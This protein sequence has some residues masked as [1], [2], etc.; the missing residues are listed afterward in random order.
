MLF[1]EISPITYKISVAKCRFQRKV[2]DMLG[3]DKFAKTQ[4]KDIL[5]VSVYEHKS[6]IRRRLGNVDMQLQENKAVNLALAAPKVDGILIK[7][8]ETFSFWQ[9]VGQTSARKG[10]KEGLQISSGRTSAG[11]GGGMCQFTNLIHWMVLHSPLDIVERHHHDKYD[12]FPDFNRQVPFGV[13]TSIFYNYLDY[14]F[15]NNTPNTYQL[16][17]RTND[18][19]L[20]GE[21]RCNSKPDYSYH[22]F[23]EDEHF[24]LEGDDVFRCGR[25]MRKTIDKLT[26][27]TVQIDTLCTNHAKVLY[28]TT[29]LKIRNM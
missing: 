17:I 14:R 1:C 22:I 2:S 25:V 10:Y 16:L 27:N 5:L 15:K 11:I 6:L 12:L 18:E 9:L 24:T 29:G 21:L 13:G 7:P 3:N 26:G 19:Y 23:T 28:D 8:G 20:C 4:S